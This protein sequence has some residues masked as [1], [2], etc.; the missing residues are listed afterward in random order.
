M[1]GLATISINKLVIGSSVR[2]LDQIW[3][4]GILDPIAPLEKVGICAMAAGA[5][6]CLGIEIAK[7]SEFIA[8]SLWSNALK[9]T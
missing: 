2:A 1:E 3:L 4:S 9:I 8:S 6:H 7:L 5:A